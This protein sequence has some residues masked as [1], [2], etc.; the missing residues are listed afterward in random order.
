MRRLFV[1]GGIVLRHTL[2]IFI[3]ARGEWVNGYDHSLHFKTI[4]EIK[5]YYSE[6]GRKPVR[7]VEL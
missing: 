2:F 5:K 1:E 4:E 3:E 6:K 7:V